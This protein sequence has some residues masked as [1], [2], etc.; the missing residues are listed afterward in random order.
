MNKTAL[1]V[2]ALHSD[3]DRAVARLLSAAL[4]D[5]PLAIFACPNSRLGAAWLQSSFLGFLSMGYARGEVEGAGEP[6]AG[7]AI[8]RRVLAPPEAE[9]PAL[10]TAHPFDE[11][12][13]GSLTTSP[14][15]G[16]M[17]LKLHVKE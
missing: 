8:T 1:D 9:T 16:N 12:L 11:R 15:T 14:F 3:Q 17:D 2:K 6:L 10:E 5:D 7:V 13:C 4:F